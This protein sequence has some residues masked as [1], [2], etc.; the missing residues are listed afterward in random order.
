[1]KTVTGRN[2][3]LQAVVKAALEQIRKQN[4]FIA[5]IIA[6]LDDMP[7]PIPQAESSP[8]PAPKYK[9]YMSAA[10]AASYC[11]YSRS[12]MYSLMC[13]KEIPYHRPAGRRAFFN[14]KELDDFMVRGKRDT[15]YEMMEKAASILNGRKR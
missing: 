15:S 4:E 8:E 9:E 3:K 2:A 7:E 5:E 14:R 11:G 12:Y 10:E 6:A 1:M 13:R